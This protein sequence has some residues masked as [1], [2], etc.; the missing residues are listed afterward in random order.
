MHYLRRVALALVAGALSLLGSA[1]PRTVRVVVA[2]DTHLL[3]PE[4]CDTTSAA[5]KRECRNDMKLT[6]LSDDILRAW[7]DEV[8]AL[9]PDV[10]LI[11]GD[12]THNGE[13]ASHEAMAQHLDV[14]RKSGIKTFVVPGNHDINNPH[15]CRHTGPRREKA[16]TVT[17]SEF[18]SIYTSHGYGRG[19]RRDEASLSYAAEPVKGLVVIAIDS[20][21]DEQNH[22]K[23]R[24]DT[25]DVY[26]NGG[27]VKESTLQWLANE[28]RRA[29]KAGKTVVAM[30]HHHG[31]DHFDGES[32]VLPKYVA[33]NAK[34]VRQTLMD[35]GVKL[36]FTGHLHV[37][38]IARA[39]GQNAGD[40]IT[41][42]A[43]CSLVS[44]P[45][46]YRVVEFR[47]REA[48]IDTRRVEATANEPALAARGRKQLTAVAPKMMKSAVNSLWRRHADKLRKFGSLA[49]AFGSD[50]P[51]DFEAMLE[52]LA[53]TACESLSAIATPAIVSFVEGNESP[54]AAKRA[55]DVLREKAADIIARFIKGPA[56]HLAQF[57]AEE[58][59]SAVEPKLK[60]LL[61]DRNYAG[62][63][64]ERRVND[65]WLKV[66]VKQ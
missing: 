11:S 16:T 47:G 4:L 44:Y 26:N 46:A 21:L 10:V 57:A 56:R 49:G 33:K 6:G 63:P 9:H 15:A 58:A 25:A 8:K 30:M 62:K 22:L 52:T 50:E 41:E 32:R 42:V 20:N 53:N 39:F 43:T 55:T 18:A 31:V 19:A 5:Y 45:F 66:V 40:S 54:T 59:I 28:T 48:S 64:N 65:H 38:D 60:S 7:V 1:A 17:R 27:A 36:L 3:A 37:N 29:A 12:L 24:G 23:S 2:S 61:E 34:E 14:L 51:L 13:R 35:N